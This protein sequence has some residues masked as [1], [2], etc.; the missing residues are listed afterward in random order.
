MVSKWLKSEGGLKFG[1]NG[2]WNTFPKSSISS[3]FHL[4]RD[5]CLET[6]PIVVLEKMYLGLSGVL[7][8][9]VQGTF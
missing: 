2:E 3:S 8:F 5:R 4:Q 1:E 6:Q 9:E 7:L